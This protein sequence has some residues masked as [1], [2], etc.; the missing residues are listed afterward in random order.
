MNKIPKVVFSRSGLVN[1]T[2]FEETEREVSPYASTW[3]E[4]AVANDLI[5]GIA[6]L[7]K[8]EGKPILAH[9]GAGFAQELVK[10]GLVDEYRFAVHPVAIGKG[11]GIF[12][13]ATHLIDLELLSS[14]AFPSGA[15]VNI[16]AAKNT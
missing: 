12:A 1:K 15:V 3:K 4:A 10:N 13:T 7:K 5:A 9:G 14:N 2:I 8:R 16:Y 6:E 11:I